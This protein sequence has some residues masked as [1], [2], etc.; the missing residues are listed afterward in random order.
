MLHSI[1][2]R[3]H[4]LVQIHLLIQAWREFIWGL[5]FT[6]QEPPFDC[7]DCYMLIWLFFFTTQLQKRDLKM[8]SIVH[9]YFVWST[10]DF[11]TRYYSILYIT[12][13]CT[14]AWKVATACV[15]VT[16]WLFLTWW[17]SLHFHIQHRPPDIHSADKDS[18]TF[19][20][21]KASKKTKFLC[22]PAAIK[23]GSL[24]VWMYLCWRESVWDDNR[25]SNYSISC[26]FFEFLLLGNYYHWQYTLCMRGSYFKDVRAVD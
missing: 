4:Y 2:L 16:G 3:N 11:K 15:V 22:N 5:V 19:C 24:T 7:I 20:R 25:F 26:H 9:Y 10:F 1:S 8:L 12:G 14:S 23:V 18:D 13:S 6:E 21:M 17:Q